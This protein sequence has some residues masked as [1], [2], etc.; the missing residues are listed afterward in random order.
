MY[1]TPGPR[2]VDTPQGCLSFD[3]CEVWRRHTLVYADESETTLQPSKHR[4][5][6]AKGCFGRYSQFHE[7]SRG[8]GFQVCPTVIGLRLGLGKARAIRIRASENK[9]GLH[10]RAMMRFMIGLILGLVIAPTAHFSIDLR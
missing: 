9:L 8:E 7:S 2:V 6:L 10:I 4:I 5:L 1:A 3:A